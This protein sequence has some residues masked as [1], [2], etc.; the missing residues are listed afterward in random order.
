MMISSY[1]DQKNSDSFSD[2]FNKLSDFSVQLKDNVSSLIGQY[3]INKFVN[4]WQIGSARKML[5]K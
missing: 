2:N 4:Y 1:T 5:S 3:S